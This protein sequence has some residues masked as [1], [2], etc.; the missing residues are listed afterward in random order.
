M[1]KA[2]TNTGEFHKG[3]A[4]SRNPEN[5]K[6]LP[7]KAVS[8]IL[9]R[10]FATKLA[11]ASGSPPSGA[12]NPGEPTNSALGCAPELSL[13]AGIRWRYRSM[14]K[15]NA[16]SRMPI[17]LARCRWFVNTFNVHIPQSSPR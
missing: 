11:P 8:A 17:A 4:P 6:L 9:V 15:V 2:A 14:R 12:P 16:T 1:A 3:R 13:A 7:Q 10:R 5:M